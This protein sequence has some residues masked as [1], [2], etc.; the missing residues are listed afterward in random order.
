MD[1]LRATRT[2][3]LPIVLV[4]RGVE[5]EIQRIPADRSQDAATTAK[6]KA[7]SQSDADASAFAVDTQISYN[8]VPYNAIVVESW[9]FRSNKGARIGQRYE[10]KGRLRKKPSLIGSPL[11]LDRGGWHD[12]QSGEPKLGLTPTD[13]FGP[14]PTTA[15]VAFDPPERYAVPD[16][17]LSAPSSVPAPAPTAVLA[18][19]AMAAPPVEI[20]PPPA[21]MAAPVTPVELAPPA[22]YTAVPVQ[23]SETPL[24]NRAM[25]AGVM[26]LA[27]KGRSFAAFAIVQKGGMWE[28]VTM[29]D[30]NLADTPDSVRAYARSRTDAEFIAFAVDTFVPVDGVEVTAVVVEVWEYATRVSF[31]VAQRYVPIG[32][33]PSPRL[34]GRPL[35]RTQAGWIPVT[36]SMMLGGQIQFAYSEPGAG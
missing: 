18:P 1:S 6:Q 2:P 10:L 36:S 33:P 29:T 27:T 12:P 25:F 3:F 11:H 9:N 21:E 19:P 31:L 17:S 22:A 20:A 7:A 28:Q 8:G 16:V 15:P 5:R 34:S 4:Q 23:R 32:D 35:M 13:Q 24:G 26:E 30:A 14:P